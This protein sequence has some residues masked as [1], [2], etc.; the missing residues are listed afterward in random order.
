MRR[1]PPL[2]LLDSCGLWWLNRTLANFQSSSHRFPRV[3]FG[4]PYF[5]SVFPFRPE[6]P[7]PQ[8]LVLPSWCDRLLEKIPLETPSFARLNK[9]LF[10]LTPPF[11]TKPPSI[12]T[13]PPF[14][15]SIANQ[16]AFSRV[17]KPCVYLQEALLPISPTKNPINPYIS[18]IALIISSSWPRPSGKRLQ[19]AKLPCNSI[20]I[21]TRGC[22]KP[23]RP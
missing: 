20:C 8:V 22:N 16:N 10:R 17:V 13:L 9:Y 15:C 12:P 5:P 11:Y 21:S 6:L 3:T 23:L 2:C 4:L 14:P 7:T 1:D 19:A 18:F